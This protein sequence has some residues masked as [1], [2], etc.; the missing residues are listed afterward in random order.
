MSGPTLSRRLLAL[1]LSAVLSL[2]LL[3]VASRAVMERRLHRPR[4]YA[5]SPVSS[6]TLLPG[7]EERHTSWEFDVTYRIVPEGYRAPAAPRR[8][9]GGPARLLV[10]GDS[11][12]FGMGVEDGETV[13]S[14]L[15]VELDGRLGRPTTTINGGFLAGKSPDDAFAFLVSEPAAELAPDAVLLLLFP[16]N[17][18]LDVEE[19]VWESLDDRGLPRRVRSPTDF[20]NRLGG[21]GPVPWHRSRPWLDGFGTLQLVMRARFATAGLDRWLKEKRAR[22]AELLADPAPL[23]A[24]FAASL[25]GVVAACAERGWP[26]AFGVVDHRS[27]LA[28][29][30]MPF[31]DRF[32]PA[33]VAW[34]RERSPAVVALDRSAGFSADDYWPEDGHWRPAGHARA[35]RALAPV[36]EELLLGTDPEDP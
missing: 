11:F 20:A 24:R 6:F 23:P 17:D 30:A 31:L 3:E 13:S 26:L 16:G 22:E 12:A 1:G 28:G 19:H 32:L 33:T 5:T 21:R 4:I 7:V 8:A 15:G 35:A 10:L 9:S 34:L 18:L 27:R 29:E 25:E 14:R 36:A 2:L